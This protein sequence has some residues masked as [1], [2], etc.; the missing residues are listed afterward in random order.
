MTEWHHRLSDA[1]LHVDLYPAATRTAML[2]Q[3]WADGVEA[4]VAVS[5]DLASSKINRELSLR[6]PGRILPVYGYHPEQVIP[7][8]KAHA[9]LLSWIRQR[10]ADGERFAIGEVGLPYYKRTSA[11]AAG[12]TLSL[13]PYIELLESF[14]GLAGELKRPIALHAVYEDAETVCDLL[15]KHQVEKAHFHWFK[16]PPQTINRMM[17]SGYYLSVTPDVAYEPEIQSLVTRYPLELMMTETDGPWPFEGPYT[18]QATC[19]G[20]TADVVRHIARL[21]GI[22]ETEAATRT[23]DNL[24]SFYGI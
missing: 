7:D 2:E 17:A 19:P 24:R 14:I 21:K 3:A 16:G 5:M 23:R 22:G 9:A 18:G 4:I 15:E 13:K 11:A 6:Y 12:E 8:R 10:A 20:M 1:H